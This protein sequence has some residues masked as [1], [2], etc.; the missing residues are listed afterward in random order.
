MLNSKNKVLNA[1]I[2]LI[3]IIISYKIYKNQEKSI[4]ALKQT[5]ELEAKKNDILGSIIESEKRIN[6]Y[7]TYVNKKDISSIINQLSIIAN[8]CSIRISSMKPLG[9]RDFPVFVRYP[10]QL[11][12]IA[13]NYDD[14]GNFISKLENS[15]DVYVIEAA[16]LRSGA[17]NAKDSKSADSMIL[18]INLYTV[19]FK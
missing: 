16:N 11:S 10:F 8:E 3:A 14:A 5:T 17:A 18:D 6:L 4:V 1:I 9:K 7:K 13:N 12:V 2:I 19:L 15:P